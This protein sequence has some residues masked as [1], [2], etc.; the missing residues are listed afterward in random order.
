MCPTHS[1]PGIWKG[2]RTMTNRAML[3]ILWS[4]VAIYVKNITV[5]LPGNH[6]IMLERPPNSSEPVQF[7]LDKKPFCANR[8][9]RKRWWISRSEE[10]ASWLPLVLDIE[11]SVH[12]WELKYFCRASNDGQVVN[13]QGKDLETQSKRKKGRQAR[14]CTYVCQ[15]H[16]SRAS[17]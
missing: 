6:C 13:V 7:I 10:L 9:S 2:Q 1:G 17:F 12:C 3:N 16:L 14:S 4:R 15:S 5:D 11:Q 8:W